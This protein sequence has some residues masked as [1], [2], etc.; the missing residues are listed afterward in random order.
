MGV[1]GGLGGRCGKGGKSPPFSQDLEV[2]I[3]LDP[4]IQYRPVTP[5]CIPKPEKF[6]AWGDFLPKREL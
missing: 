2:E 6:P 3:Y 5:Y 4:C 1:A